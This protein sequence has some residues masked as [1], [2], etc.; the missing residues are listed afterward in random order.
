MTAV[1]L[2]A[3]PAAMT[4][5]EIAA[6][7][8][9]D[10]K[11]VL[12]DADSMLVTLG[13]GDG[14]Y[15]Q[16]WTDPQNG[17]SY[18]ELALPKDL[19]L[20]LVSGY[21]VEMRH[22]IVTR[23]QELEAAQAPK[24]PDLSDPA[25]LRGLLLNYTE[26]VLALET[27]IVTQAPKVAFAEAVGA[28]ED[29]QKIHQVAKVLGQGPRKFLAWLK[30]TGILMTNGLPVQVHI[31]LNRF[32]VIEVPYKDNEKRDR[33]RLETRITGRGVTFLQQRLAKSKTLEAEHH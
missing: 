16:N 33:M 27:T 24:L 8:G 3:V 23:W 29:L 26:R 1:T 6:L 10:H 9:K 19:T 15:V 17:R 22:R 31:D 2:S 11:H 14:G 25:A 21:S 13:L 7:T 4:T 5:R 30:D 20:T 18:R 12:R 32:R 28:A